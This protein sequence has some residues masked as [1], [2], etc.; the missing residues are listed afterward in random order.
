MAPKRVYV[1]MTEGDAIRGSEI[2]CQSF[3]FRRTDW[4]RENA[5]IEDQ[6]EMTSGRFE[7]LT[8]HLKSQYTPIGDKLYTAFHIC[9]AYES[10]HDLD[11]FRKRANFMF[12]IMFYEIFYQDLVKSIEFEPLTDHR[13]KLDNLSYL[14]E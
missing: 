5:I 1:I 9:L 8:N 7:D 3:P 4:Q 14:I 2:W 11:Q 12:K 10:G 6:F 13:V